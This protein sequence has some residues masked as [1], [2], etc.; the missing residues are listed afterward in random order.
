M[1]SLLLTLIIGC[2]S[3]S[4]KNIGE[5]CVEQLRNDF[6]EYAAYVI[7]PKNM[8]KSCAATYNKDMMDAYMSGRVGLVFNCEKSDTIFI[9]DYIKGI[10]RAN[11]I[12]DTL[13]QY[14]VCDSIP[15]SIYPT[16]IYTKNKKIVSVE[17]LNKHNLNAFKRL[18]KKI[19]L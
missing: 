18:K 4:A 17:Y 11:V 1:R 2:V 6:P 16:V 3:C 5:F 14:T 15:E 13:S 12:I 7:I 19:S 9:N 10:M 8:C